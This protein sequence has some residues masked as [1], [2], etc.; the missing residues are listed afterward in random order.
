MFTFWGPHWYIM[1]QHRCSRWSC[2]PFT[3]WRITQN[4]GKNSSD[5]VASL[6]QVNLAIDNP[7]IT[8]KYINSHFFTYH[9]TC[10]NIGHIVGMFL[11]GQIISNRK[12]LGANRN[13][14]RNLGME[15]AIRVSLWYDSNRVSWLWSL[16]KVNVVSLYG[17]STC[18][19]AD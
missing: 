9:H 16:F 5:T 4:L 12:V 15:L 17:F 6:Y 7:N 8:E 10:L 11:I 13:E 3:I 19:L 1:S 18:D 14:P 2:K